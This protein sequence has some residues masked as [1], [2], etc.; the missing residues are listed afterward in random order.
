MLCLGSDR[1]QKRFQLWL[2]A[3]PARVIIPPAALW[4]LYMFYAAG[5]QTI[6]FQGA[7]AMAL[8][9][10]VPFLALSLTPK[11]E[12]AVILWLWLPLELGI[13]RTILIT[14]RPGPDLHYVFAQLLAIDA[15]II[16]FAVWNR[17]PKIGYRFEA[18]RT[19][20]VSGFVHFAL[21]AVIAIPLGLA[22][23]FIRY[24]FAASK[25]YLAPVLFLGIFFFT[26]LP[27]EFL[28]R[29]LIQNWIERVT[30][31]RTASLLAASVI[32]GASHL[33]NG[34]PFPNYK[35]FLMATIAGWFYGRA[36][37]TTGSLM[38]SSFTHALV[39]TL[40]SVIFR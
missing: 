16:A 21:F 8:Y 7:A 9:L 17:T 34:P 31:R 10:A 5:M 36:W 19:I 29:G 27:E 1:I 18:D 4:L 3:R 6:T 39:D 40:W 37:R 33:N 22:I 32:F 25:L 14:R 30:G 23:G 24:S 38:A 20:A 26:A 2:H 13:L 28:F 12:P 11:L 35:Y 15:G